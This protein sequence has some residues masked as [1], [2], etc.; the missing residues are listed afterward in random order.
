MCVLIVPSTSGFL[1]SSFFSPQ[2][3]LFPKIN[4]IEIRPLS[5]PTIVSKCQ[6]KGSVIYLYFKS[7][8]EIIQLSEEGMLK[9]CVQ[10]KAR[11]L[12]SVSQVR[13][14]KEKS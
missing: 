7:K 11:S 5:N 10:A 1:F 3:S 8:L 9:A 13:N 4:N 12:A 14:A 6:V 2:A